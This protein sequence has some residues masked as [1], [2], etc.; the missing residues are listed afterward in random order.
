MNGRG[1][2]KDVEMQELFLRQP[3]GNL[4][5]TIRASLLEI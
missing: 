3:R 1:I 2:R 4:A 5:K